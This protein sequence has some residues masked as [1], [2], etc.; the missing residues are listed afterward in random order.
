MTR[1]QRPAIVDRPGLAILLWVAMIATPLVSGNARATD[2]TTL[3]TPTPFEAHYTAVYQGARFRDAAIRRLERLEDGTYRHTYEAEHMVY[4]AREESILEL[5]GCQAKSLSYATE[6][7]NLFRRREKT[8]R[9]DWV[10]Q[11]AFYDDEGSKGTFPLTPDVADPMTSQLVVA[12]QADGSQ[13]VIRTVETDDNHSE[14]R[15]WLMMG[16]VTL[17]TRGGDVPTFKV[18][19]KHANPERQTVMWLSADNPVMI[20]RIWQ[21]DADGSIYILELD[22]W[23]PLAA[24]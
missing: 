15:D 19:R 6:R 3:R 1:M 14:P 22:N 13:K 11:E 7:G 20:V 10:K 2:L 12:C 23:K 4:F 18:E 8:L 17:K 24:K 5:K 16:K 21:R 9:F